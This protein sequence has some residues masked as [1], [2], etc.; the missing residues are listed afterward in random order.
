MSKFSKVVIVGGG[1]AGWLSALYANK[2][3]P[4]SD[5]TLIEK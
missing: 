2:I 3:S 1:A 5:I 4:E